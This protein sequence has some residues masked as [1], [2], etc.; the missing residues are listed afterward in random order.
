MDNIVKIAAV[1]DLMCG[2][3]FYHIGSGIASNI[4]RL[5]VNFLMPDI[6]DIFRSHDIVF[7][8]IESPISNIG[9]QKNKLRTLH[10]RGKPHA[11]SL[12]KRWGITIGNVANNHIFEHGKEA[13]IDTIKNLKKANISIIGGGY[14]ED[15][16]DNSIAVEH[17]CLNNHN[18]FFIG[19]C[20]RD[21]KYAYNGGCNVDTV[22]EKISQIKKEYPNSII[23]L[24][25]HWGNEFISYP[26]LK[27]IDQTNSFFHAGTNIILGHHPHVIQGLTYKDNK[28]VAYSLGNFIFDGYLP[29]TNWSYILSITIKNFKIY[30]YDIIPIGKNANHQPY[31]F[32]GVEKERYIKEIDIRS[33]IINSSAI[34]EEK[35]K[36][37]V[38]K[39]K[40]YSQ[41]MLYLELLKYSFRYKPIFWHQ[42]LQRPIQRRLNKW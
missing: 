14:N 29:D 36:L 18:I 31:I 41:K 37:E 24:S 16:A 11:A 10:M 26:S 15:F 2:D 4:E 6:V 32:K 23:I 8:N 19:I 35:Y 28:L 22:I 42:I 1:G 30:N 12:L 39:L 34:N 38:E 3:S 17:I 40:K 25:A 13:A 9:F 7:A 20:F 33:N 21:E 5:G 27:Q